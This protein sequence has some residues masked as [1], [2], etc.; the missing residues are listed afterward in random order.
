MKYN[1]KYKSGFRFYL[2]HSYVLSSKNHLY[3]NIL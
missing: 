3:I 2:D 1:I